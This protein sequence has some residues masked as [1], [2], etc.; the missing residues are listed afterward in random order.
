MT[1]LP[2]SRLVNVTVNL[3]PALAQFPNL[4]SCLILGTSDVINVQQRIQSF[5][6]LA[7]V[8]AL[9]GG[10]AQETLAATLWFEQAPQPTSLLI[11]RWADVDTAG[12]LVGASLSATEQAI[13]NWNA[14]NNGA[15]AVTIDG[16][17]PQQVGGL[18]FS[19]SANLNAVA[20]V[21][22]AGLPGG[23][24]I[25]TW[26]A[27]MDSFTITSQ[28]TGAA[29][30]IS[31]L[32]S[33]AAG[34]D[35]SATL[36][37]TAASSGAYVADGIVAETAL[38]AV[39]IFQDRF[40]SQWYGLV[41]PSADND[42]HVAIAGY[43]N[44]ANPSHFYGVTSQDV[45]CLDPDSELDIAF[46][47]KDL[48]YEQCAV[49]YSSTNAYAVVSL[50]GRIL[51]T[52]YAGNNTVI[53]LMY[54][55]EPGITAETLSTTQINAL[56]DKNANVFVNYNNDTAIIQPGITPS[57]QYIDTVIGIDW[58]QG[59]IQTNVY[60]L[61]YGSTTKIPQTD[62]GNQQI[63]TQ[64]QAACQQGVVN[65]LLAPGV[66][67]AGGF[68]QLTQGAF[69]PQGFYIYTPPISS[70]AQADRTARRSVAFQIAAKLAGAVQTVSITLN[71]N[72]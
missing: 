72:P 2:V 5:S 29:S 67:N 39:T 71:V 1:G 38:E 24:A 54:K 8:S 55:T 48:A 21:I 44:A 10:S 62:A 42:D 16:V 28:T 59:S 36:G 47:L 40:S 66:W 19:A 6:T 14:I 15:F 32:T 69:L 7:E 35:I 65:G 53:T 22:T 43:I 49:Q 45:A 13:A 41:I 61:L 26:D 23:T 12:L 17:G 46:L 58:L 68:G 31:F 50:L 37:M 34:T 70:Q 56:E 64:I 4:S 27:T 30:T 57:G 11:G 60:N 33:P 3:S 51:T 20:A 52:N 18:D 9:F 25:C 63:A